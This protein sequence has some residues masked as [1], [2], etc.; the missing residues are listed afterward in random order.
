MTL[1][2]FFSPSNLDGNFTSFLTFTLHCSL[3]LLSAPLRADINT[4]VLTHTNTHTHTHTHSLSLSLSLF[5]HTIFGFPWNRTMRGNRKEN[6][7]FSSYTLLYSLNLLYLSTCF[8]FFLNMA[9]PRG[10]SPS[11]IK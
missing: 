4:H 6:F 3:D 11:R 8:Y 9:K 10:F 1:P 5:T 7:C 2:N